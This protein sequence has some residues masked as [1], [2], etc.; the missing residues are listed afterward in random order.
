[1]PLLIP[2]KKGNESWKHF[3]V[4]MVYYISKL[5]EKFGI[6]YIPT[7]G[8]DPEEFYKMYVNDVNIF[9]GAM[10]WAPLG[11]HINIVKLMIEKGATDFNLGMFK[12]AIGGH[13]DIVK[14][15]IE[16]G[17]HNFNLAMEGAASEGHMDI[18]KLMIEK[19]ATY[20]NLPMK[21]AALGGHMDI[22]NYLK[23]FV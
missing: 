12:A 8:Y 13:M 19:G 16:K 20:F 6:P 11:G 1:Y 4:K 17:A 23:Q 15:M 9:N 14:L 2:L 3:Y 22:V 5:K 21:W 7:K 10:G 18:V